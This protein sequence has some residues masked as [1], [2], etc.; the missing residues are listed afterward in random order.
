[1]FFHKKT[2]NST[3]RI[4]FAI[5]LTSVFSPFAFANDKSYDS[6]IYEARGGNTQ[7]ALR[8][9]DRATDL[10]NEKIADWMQIASW[11]NNDALV[12]SLYDR[13]KMNQLP[14]RAYQAAA[15]AYRNQKRFSE[16]AQIWKYL[17][18][19][20]PVNVAYQDGYV[21]TLAE[22]GDYPL[23]IKKMDSLLKKH[24]D[25]R[26]YLMAA[27]VYRLAGRNEESLF[28]ATMAMQNTASKKG[29]T[30]LHSRALK[31]N[32]LSYVALRDNV[33]TDKPDSRADQAAELVRLAFTP[34]RSEQE[35]YQIADRALASY[36]SMLNEWRNKKEFEPYYKRVAVDQLGALLARDKHKEVLSTKTALERDGIAIPAYARYWI[37]SAYLHEKQPEEA[38]A[39]LQNMFNRDGSVS[40][41]ITEPQKSD[42]FYS[43]LE[44]GDFDSAYLLTE[45]IVKNTPKHTYMPGSPTPIENYEWLQGQ[46]FLA[47]LYRYNND[48]QKAENILSKLTQQAPGNQGLKIDYASLLLARGLPR[49]A[50]QEL[51]KAELLEPTNINLEIEQSYTA[52]ELQ[53][54]DDAEA[55]LEDVVKRAPD[56]MAVKNLKRAH[57]IHNSAELRV[58]ATKNLDS[59][60]PDSGKHDSAMNAVLYTPPLAK[61]WR[62][63][64]GFGHTDSHF[65][66]GDGT[67]ND[68]ST[69]LEW[70]SRDLWLEGEVS[71]RDIEHDKKVG[72]RLSARYDIDDHFSVGTNV[73]RISR[74]TP[75]R[76]LKHGITANSGE[77]SLNW[78]KNEG[79]DIG[80]SYS[81]SDFTDGNKRSEFALAG[82]KN[83][84][85]NHKTQVDVNMEVYYG[86]N[87]DLDTPYYNPKQI[88]DVLPSVDVNNTIYE[89]Y[90]T[91]LTQQI[92]AGVGNRWEKKYGSGVMTQ[93]SYGQR[94]SWDDKHSIGANVSWTKRPYDG[95]REHNLAIGLD[96][97]VRF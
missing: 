36:A 23:A 72:A 53:E 41:S 33:S 50:E 8:Y 84:W 97:T 35:R 68:W 83:I 28:M 34:S 74:K 45:N 16:S 44:K 21:Q 4:I 81:Y 18:E 90:S 67:F 38:S 77:L 7:P 76:A 69:G 96:M 95:K 40:K 14:F 48:L 79:Q 13:Y 86:H 27:Y 43:Y 78:R 82:G 63:F 15:T 3:N 11:A 42:L 17:C 70:R 89:N 25:D 85:A 75:S 92:S 24:P 49:Q 66:E 65:P 51:K 19:K 58:E 32:H 2:G 88:V 61:N 80:F 71:N 29:N 12:I 59:N 39:I 46:L 93:V 55:L 5:G 91:T 57:D 9:F 6:L 22:S 73:E 62:A 54:W 31:D 26:H 94:F 37:A 64:V 20:D 60:S 1:M 10:N 30:E 47:E 56:N 87:K 52:L